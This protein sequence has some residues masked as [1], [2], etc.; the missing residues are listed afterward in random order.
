MQS[1]FFNHPQ[2]SYYD[3]F[4]I[5]FFGILGIFFS[6]FLYVNQYFIWFWT[7]GGQKQF[8]IIKP[9]AACALKQEVNETNVDSWR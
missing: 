8:T 7:E 5:D 2:F 9:L 4:I 3:I 1:K 6:D